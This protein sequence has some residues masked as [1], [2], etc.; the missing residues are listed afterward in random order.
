MGTDG[1]EI[2]TNG[3]L[4][5][6]MNDKQLAAFAAQ[7]LAAY[8]QEKAESVGRTL[9]ATERETIAE[10]WFRVMMQWFRTPVEIGGK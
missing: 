10:T 8:E 2:R 5:R 1:D 6:G 9:T 7:K 3:D 4:I